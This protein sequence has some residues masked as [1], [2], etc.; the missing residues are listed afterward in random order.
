MDIAAPGRPAI[1]A[2]YPAGSASRSGAFRSFRPGSWGLPGV[3]FFISHAGRDRAWAEW[4]AWHLHDAGYTVELDTWDW[5]AGDNFVTKMA[6]ALDGAERVVALFSP[7]YFEP[8]RYTTDEWASAFVHDE[9]QRPRLLPLVVEECEPPQLL[10]PLIAQKLFG[11]DEDQARKALLDAARGPKRPDGRPEFPPSAQARGQEAGSRPRVPGSPPAVWNVPGRNSDF[12]GRDGVLVPLRER[13]LSCKNTQV[14][15]GIG[16]VGKTQLAIEYAH[17]FAAGYDL[18]WWIDSERTGLISEQF[19][20]L[21]VAAGLVGTNTDHTAAELAVRKYFRENSRWLLVFDNAEDPDAVRPW[22]SGAA[23][24]VLITSRNPA[25][26]EIGTRT[27]VQEFQRQESIA[28]LRS[29]QP[30]LADAEADRL[31]DELGDLPL[32][33]AQAGG[34]L[35]ETGLS[36]PEYLRL[37]ESRTNDVLNE[38]P[39]SSY[40]TSLAAAVRV[41]MERLAADEPAAVALLQVCAMFAPEP[42]PTGW[43]SKPEALPDELAKVAGDPLAFGKLVARIGR[44]G[45]ARVGNAT[46][47]LHRLVRSVIRDQLSVDR[48]NAL[49]TSAEALLAGVVPGSTE[50]PAAWPE[51]A[52]LLPHLVEVDP[53]TTENER[54][55]SLACDAALYLLRRGDVTSAMPFVRRLYERWRDRIGPDDV[56]TLTA[57]NEVAHSHFQLGEYHEAHA[58]IEDTLPRW[59]ENFG[60]NHVGTLRSWNDLAV[61][62]GKLGQY[63]LACEAQEAVWEKRRYLLGEDHPETLYAMTNLANVLNSSDE[64]LRARELH[65]TAWGKYRHVL[66]D[67]HPYV[68]R[69]MNSLARALAS[70]GEVLRARELCEEAWEKSREMLGEEHPDVLDLMAN[71]AYVCEEL[72]DFEEA[73]RLWREAWQRYRRVLGESHPD[74]LLAEANLGVALIRANRSPQAR[75][76]LADVHERQRAIFGFD[77]PDVM[78]TYSWLAIALYRVGKVARARR[79]ADTVMAGYRRNF[80]ENS[81]Q[82]RQTVE[83]LRPILQAKSRPAKRR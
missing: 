53:A 63:A 83:H 14:L 55:R 43:L 3:D 59:Q 67:D 18:V 7:A 58:L 6:A 65:E 52:R 4:V 68:L 57:A 31:A 20:A 28:L 39:P 26:N 73:C 50:D 74:A 1:T 77:H 75:P 66:G 42:I 30:A 12:T 60:D 21:A 40:P 23:G 64:E 17:G 82:M 72:G 51:W 71:S 38:K 10:R 48:R 22:L 61:I 24:H 37:L 69:A 47:R 9:Q 8:Q 13:L 76:L 33:L 2:R 41:S 54:L 62:L 80:G 79:V 5:A 16:G 27:E 35:A 46:I 49:H 34:T 44:I 25:W 81:Y 36:V 29:R 32:A 19:A 45:L 70:T 15:H 11:L 78:R 56:H